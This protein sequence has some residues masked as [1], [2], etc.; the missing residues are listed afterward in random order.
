MD[1]IPELSV[2]I[3]TFVGQGI[4]LPVQD[5]ANRNTNPTRYVR[6]SHEWRGWSCEVG[7][8]M[9]RFYR[10]AKDG[11]QVVDMPRHLCVV[12]Y[13]ELE[14]EKKGKKRTS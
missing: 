11:W 3:V 7:Q 13:D 1:E 12:E 9:V 5:R 10:Q 8:H 4:Y 14:V 2:K 6:D